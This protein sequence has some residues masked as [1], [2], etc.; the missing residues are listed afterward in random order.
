[1]T[2]LFRGPVQ[3]A[4]VLPGVPRAVRVDPRRPPLLR[5]I[6]GRL[7]PRASSRRARAAHAG[8]GLLR[9][10]SQIRAHRATVLDRAYAANPQR[11]ARPPTPPRLPAIAWINQ[12]TSEALI[13]TR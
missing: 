5:G 13:Q 12:P 9:H 4:Q 2:T 10:R 1:M 3:D 11:F 7:Q 8:V 6:L